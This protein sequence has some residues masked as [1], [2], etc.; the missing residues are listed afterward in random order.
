MLKRILMLGTVFS[1]L[2]SLPSCIVTREEYDA[3]A[4]D[5]TAIEERLTEA[6]NTIESLNADVATLQ[7]YAHEL[8][9]EKEDLEGKIAEASESE[10]KLKSTIDT[11]NSMIADM[12]DQINNLREK[13]QEDEQSNNVISDWWESFKNKFTK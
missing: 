5:K 7:Q 10:K 1:M 11:Q 6:E 9:L 8:E 13:I 4:A 3:L 2:I 12:M